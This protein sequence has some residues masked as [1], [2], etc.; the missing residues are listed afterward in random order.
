MEVS[1]VV[2]T[3]NRKDITND[4]LWSSMIVH[5]SEKNESHRG[6]MQYI[7]GFAATGAIKA[8]NKYPRYC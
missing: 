1:W 2:L 6:R 5:G 7:S 8:K 4:L 3:Y